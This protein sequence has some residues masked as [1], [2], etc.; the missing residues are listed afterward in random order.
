MGVTLKDLT[1]EGRHFRHTLVVWVR[2]PPETAFA[3]VSDITRHNEWT[4]N[5]VKITPLTPG[6]VRLG[7]KYAA[8]G[9]QGGKDWPSELEVTG[10]EPPH[11][12]E[13]TATGGPIGTP[14]GDPHRHEFLFAP[15]NG[16]TQLEVR[17]M[18]PAPANWPSWFM[19]I[20]ASLIASNFLMPVRKRTVENLQAR[21][22]Q[23]ADQ[24]SQSPA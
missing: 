12:F 11:R 22:D 8:V 1:V 10:Y 6:P 15:Q 21:L 14:E 23:P 9:R 5:Q 4:V 7:S 13:F 18:D 16:G 19:K 24:P 2:V 3:Y 17:R 20:F